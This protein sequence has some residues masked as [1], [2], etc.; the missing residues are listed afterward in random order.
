M[1]WQR[2]KEYDTLKTV[3]QQDRKKKPNKPAEYLKY[4]QIKLNLTSGDIKGNAENT[5]TFLTQFMSQN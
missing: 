3:R 4:D 5:N 2:V 1:F